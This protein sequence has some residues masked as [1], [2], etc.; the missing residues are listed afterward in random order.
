MNVLDLFSGIGGFSLGLARAGFRTVAFAEIE[1][2]CKQVLA[3]HWPTVPQLGDIT[4]IGVEPMSSSED[5]LARTSALPGEAPALPEIVRLSGGGYAEP[6]AW[7]DRGTQSWRTWQRCLLE[8]WTP[9]AGTWPRSG[10]TRNG[11]AYQLPTLAP[12]TEETESGLWPTPRAEYDSGKHKGKP[13]TLHSAV[14]M[15]PTPHGFS[16]DGGRSNGPSGNELGRA[17]NRAMWPTPTSRDYKDG[18][19]ISCAN[20][21]DNGLLGRVVHKFPTPTVGDS[22]NARNSTATRHKL[23]PTGVHA[24]DTLTDAV[25]PIG[26][27]LNPTWVEWLMGYPLGWTVLKDWGTRSSR[28][29]RKSS[30]PQS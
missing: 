1:P 24:G 12:L 13:D 28:K 7:Y 22:K 20:V 5:S 27:S 4:T 26:G 2:W 17:V 25:V 18:S 10:M 29:S 19:A 21:P 16:K 9:F 14:K 8:G 15:W 23:P 11:I 6:F 3:K 30:E